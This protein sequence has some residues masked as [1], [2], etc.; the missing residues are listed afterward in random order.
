MYST[1][2][3]RQM[4]TYGYR[5]NYRFFSANAIVCVEGEPSDEVFF[6]LEGQVGASV[7]RKGG[8]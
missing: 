1:G 8:V 6:V 5:V 4:C 3:W 7:G 2:K